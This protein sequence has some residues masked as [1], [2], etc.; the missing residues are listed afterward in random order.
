MSDDTQSTPIPTNSAEPLLSASFIKPQ[1]VVIFPNLRNNMDRRA[2]GLGLMLTGTSVEKAGKAWRA[3]I[4]SYTVAMFD[5]VLKQLSPELINQIRVREEDIRPQLNVL[6]E[7]IK[8][9]ENKADA[10]VERVTAILS[11]FRLH[12]CLPAVGHLTGC[13]LVGLEAEPKHFYCHYALVLYLVGKDRTE[14]EDHEAIRK[15]LPKVLARRAMISPS[16]LV[17]SGP[18]RLSRVSYRSIKE[19]WSDLSALRIVSISE[20]S[21]FSAP[22]TSIGQ[23]LVFVVIRILERSGMK[24]FDI[25]SFFLFKYPWAIQIPQLRNAFSVLRSSSEELAT[26]D[27]RTQTLDQL[28]YLEKSRLFPQKGIT[29]LVACAVADNKEI[30]GT[31]YEFYVTSGYSGVMEDFLRDKDSREAEGESRSESFEGWELE[32]CIKSLTGNEKRELMGR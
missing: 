18:A 7:C 9:A 25:A 21:K 15:M 28:I 23:D 6:K 10:D 27:Q 2:L 20:F 4:S 22:Q 1:P 19:A 31:L 12:P 13:E 3:Y 11:G 5:G 17:L 24:D 16:A 8:L 30:A 29:P 32:D 14:K 26:T